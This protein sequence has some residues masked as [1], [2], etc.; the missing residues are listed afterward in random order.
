MNIYESGE[1]GLKTILMRK[2]HKGNV[3]SIDIAHEITSK[4]PGVSLGM[5]E[6]QENDDITVNENG[7]IH[8][9]V[10]GHDL[11]QRIDE[12][13]KVLT[14]MLKSLGVTEE[15][16]KKDASELERV[17]SEE[18]FARIKEYLC[19]NAIQINEPANV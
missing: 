15:T 13:H 11:A 16:A 1:D 2:E 17:L 6:F 3:R 8:L 5:K 18:S 7:F 4:K 9:T 10:A 19:K 12:R 14:Q